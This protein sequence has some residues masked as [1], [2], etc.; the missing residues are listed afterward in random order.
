MQLDAGS[1]HQID[2]EIVDS[3]RRVY[4]T[5]A[6]FTVALIIVGYFTAQRFADLGDRQ[7]RDHIESL[8]I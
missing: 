4:I 7:A 1:D 6:S 2:S 8:T 5:I 3:R